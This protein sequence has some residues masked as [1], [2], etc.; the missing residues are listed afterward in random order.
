MKTFVCRLGI[1]SICCF[2]SVNASADVRWKSPTGDWSV[3]KNWDT[4]TKPSVNDDAYVDNKGTATVEDTQSVR[5]ATA[6]YD[7][8]GTIIV[9]ANGVLNSEDSI[10]AG[11]N[12]GAIGTFTVDGGTVTSAAGLY[13]GTNYGSGAVNVLNG[14]TITVSALYFGYQAGS[15]QLTIDGSGSKIT[16]NTTSGNS[17]VFGRGGTVSA[18][19]N[20][21]NGGQLI[22]NG[23]NAYLGNTGNTSATA[24]IDGA[25]SAWKVEKKLFIGNSGTGTLTIQNGGLVS[26]GEITIGEKGSIRIGVGGALAIKYSSTSSVGDSLADFMALIK[27]TSKILYLAGSDWVDIETGIDGVN[28][29]L[30]RY[31]EDGVTYRR[32][33]VQASTDFRVA[34]L[35]SDNMV[36]QQQRNIAI[37]GWA[38]ANSTVT[39]TPDW[40]APVSVV[41]DAAGRW[42]A[43]VLTPAASFTPH[44]LTLDDDQGNSVTLTNVL[45]GEV[46]V[47]SGQSN[48][49]WPLRLTDDG[50]AAIASANPNIRLF[51]VPQKPSK[52]LLVSCGGSWRVADNNT[53]PEFSAVAYYFGRE[54]IEQLDVP[55]GLIHSSWGGTPAEAWTP[56]D[57]YLADPVLRPILDRKVTEAKHECSS[58]YNAMIHP[59]VKYAIKGVIWNQG[60]NNRSRAEE[61]KAL[62]PA[63]INSWRTQWN[64]NDL[65]FYFVQIAPFI[66]GHPNNPQPNGTKV[67]ELQEAQLYTMKTVPH[68]GMVVPMDVGNLTDIHPRNKLP[69]G[70]RLALWALAK[71]Y[72]RDVLYSGPV[73]REM[74][75]E[76]SRARILFDYVDG[77]LKTNDG[78]APNEFTI[79]GSDMVFYSATAII[80]G[81]T[82]LVSSD[83]VEHPVAVRYCWRNAA[84]GNLFNVNANLPASSFRTDILK[85]GVLFQIRNAR[86]D[87]IPAITVPAIDLDSDVHRIVIVDKEKDQYLGQV[88]TTRLKDSEIIFAAYP[89]GHGAGPIVLKRSDDGG[90]TWSG[91]LKTPASFESSRETPTI[92]SVIDADGV[93]RLILWSGLYPARMAHSEDKGETWSELA[94][95]GDWGGIVVMGFVEPL[96]TKGCYIAMFHD[97][98][99]LFTGKGE[100]I[101]G[102]RLYQTFSRDGG[103]TWSMPELVLTSTDTAL[104]EPYALR[105]PDG[106]QLAVLLRD[107]SRTKSS[108][109]IFS[110]DEG[111]TWSKPRELPLSLT[112][113]RHTGRYTSD[114]RLFISFRANSPVS[115]RPSRIFE[116]DWVGWVGT[117][118]DIVEGREGQYIVRLKK[119]FRNTHG[120]DSRYPGYDCGYPGV[121]T[122][123]DNTVICTSYGHWVRGEAPYIIS[124]RFS[125]TELD[126][127]VK[128]EAGNNGCQ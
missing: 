54:L 34:S 128:K 4:G 126:E 41:A 102:R 127:L 72:G 33:T 55:I 108:H 30:D 124:M 48:M 28:Y 109:V 7:A 107:S 113:D 123:Q 44:T 77:G 67:P 82:V 18:T 81:S 115:A 45:V 61:Y 76:G 60:E 112:G 58:L 39:V 15:Q 119:N 88:S 47:C 37:W 53:L 70:Q 2:L 65:P 86:T 106:N 32:L 21:T 59:L 9:T 89:K 35:F 57:V 101:K 85:P 100:A 93:E 13:T 84:E 99:K 79:A 11:I 75:V 114:G 96:K 63:M 27:G 36:L 104:C 17:T 66:L 40:T 46:W 12:R 16:V 121:E 73:Y 83:D 49:F 90:F 29:F 97:N 71:T 52:E 10:R 110:D 62:F 103:L 120:W 8:A 74:V 50:A 92:H 111:I 43:T 122:L 69:V 19:V 5:S 25:G 95:A 68:T 91:R 24:L 56:Q 105:S 20:L 14:G 80:D 3:G 31:S 125:L 38:K 22:S 117:Y 118:E 1:V 87:I 51:T 94:A 78:K 98:G 26:A 64:Q 6:G 42:S 116:K 23:G